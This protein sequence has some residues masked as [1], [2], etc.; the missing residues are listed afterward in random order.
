MTGSASP[1]QGSTL[2]AV[3][4]VGEMGRRETGQRVSPCQLEMQVTWSG[5][6]S[7]SLGCQGG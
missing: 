5:A 7:G 2:D 4:G 1:S 3:G 6:E